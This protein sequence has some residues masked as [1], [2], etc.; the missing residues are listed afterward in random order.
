MEVHNADRTPQMKAAIL[1]YGTDGYGNASSFASVHTVTHSATGVPT[2]GHGTPAS[3][4]GVLAVMRELVDDRIKPELIPANVLARGS[5]HLVWFRPA[6]KRDVWFRCKELGERRALVPHPATLWLVNPSTG[7]CQIFALGDDQRPDAGAKLYQA[8]YFNVWDSGRICVG[9]AEVPK[10][11]AALSPENW[12]SMFFNS[13]FS[14]PNTNKLVRHREGT[15]AFL[16]NLLDGKHR[17]FPKRKLVPTKKTLGE[18]FA[19]L[20]KDQQ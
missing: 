13:W 18:E 6:L 2:I 9:N 14:H 15:F 11:A 12:E 20:F 16:K 7:F 8:P 17:S 3:R 10:G 19:K 4:E 1:L 5:D